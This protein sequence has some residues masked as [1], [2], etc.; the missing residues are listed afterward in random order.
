MG[1]P[2]DKQIYDA[3]EAL[4]NKHGSKTA[5]AISL[6]IS[7]QYLNDILHFRRS[8]SE[9]VGR[10]LGFRRMIIWIKDKPQ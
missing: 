3:L 5:A 1:E 4:I 8:V 6:G 10:A 9:R 2:H 7:S